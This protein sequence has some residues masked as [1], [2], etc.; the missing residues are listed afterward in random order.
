MKYQKINKGLQLDFVLYIYVGP[1]A[2]FHTYI[3]ILAKKLIYLMFSLCSVLFFT[4]WYCY[5]KNIEKSVHSLP[6]SAT[7]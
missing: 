4:W 7:E 5:K 6:L 1:E 2:K 3:I